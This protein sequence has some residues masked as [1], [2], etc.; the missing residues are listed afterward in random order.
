MR[1]EKKKEK[2]KTLPVDQRPGSP[3]PTAYFLP[4]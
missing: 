2:E 4:F 3:T 1:K